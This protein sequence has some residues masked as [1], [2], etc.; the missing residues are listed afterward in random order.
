M[1]TSRSVCKWQWGGWMHWEVPWMK[2]K[3]KLLVFSGRTPQ[4]IQWLG[5]WGLGLQSNFSFTSCSLSLCDT[6]TV[7]GHTIWWNR[8]GGKQRD[9]EGGT[10]NKCVMVQ[11]LPALSMSGCILSR[12]FN[13]AAESVDAPSSVPSPRLYRSLP[14]SLHRDS[15]HTQVLFIPRSKK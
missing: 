8:Q 12:D 9:W 15:A 5:D 2:P 11:Y 6:H 13:L 14:L 1:V 3:E 4:A 10:L 7:G